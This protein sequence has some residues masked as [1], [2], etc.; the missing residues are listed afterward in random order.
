MR[1]EAG[2]AK[3]RIPE[4]VWARL[5]I[6]I[7]PLQVCRL[8]GR[9]RGVGPRGRKKK[10]AEKVD[11][12]SRPRISV[13]EWTIASCYT[14]KFAGADRLRSIS[15]PGF[16]TSLEPQEVFLLTGTLFTD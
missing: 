7:A 5:R 6:L 4:A 15:F 12:L 2:L 10:G 13:S 3:R 9:G 11:A 1:D 16:R 8:H 14:E